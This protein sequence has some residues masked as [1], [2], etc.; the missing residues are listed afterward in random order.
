MTCQDHYTPVGIWAGCWSNWE[1]WPCVPV[2]FGNFL[3]LFGCEISWTVGAV[4]LN[5]IWVWFTRRPIR[6]WREVKSAVHSINYTESC[7][8]HKMSLVISHAQKHAVLLALNVSVPWYMLA[9]APQHQVFMLTMKSACACGSDWMRLVMLSWLFVSLVLNILSE[10][11]EPDSACSLVFIMAAFHLGILVPL[12][13]V[14]QL[15][16]MTY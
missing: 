1:H 5:L 2:L 13:C 3:V 11:S 14:W 10:A 4:R 9:K 15:T 12:Y 8:I 6:K 7:F 16:D